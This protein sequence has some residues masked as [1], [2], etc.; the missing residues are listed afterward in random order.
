MTVG[1]K[2]TLD[3]RFKDFAR[4]NAH[5]AQEAEEGGLQEQPGV[6]SGKQFSKMRGKKVPLGWRN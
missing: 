5:S 6:H 1:S 3:I 2:S 4:Y